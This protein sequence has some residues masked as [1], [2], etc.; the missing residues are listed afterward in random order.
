MPNAVEPPPTIV[1]P[2]V[3]SP[4]TGDAILIED[5]VADALQRAG[6]GFGVGVIQIVGGPGAGK[7]VA[8]EYLKSVLPAR[9]SLEFI[10]AELCSADL[11]NRLV[12]ALRTLAAT[13]SPE[14]LAFPLASPAILICAGTQPLDD[15]PGCRIERLRL[16]AWGDDERIE[17]LLAAHPDRCASVI[18]RLREAEDR[19]IL[20]GT[21]ELCRPVLDQMAADESITSSLEALRRELRGRL[22]HGRARWQLARLALA[23]LVEPMPAAKE[24]AAWRAE[25]EQTGCDPGVLRLARHEAVRVLLAAELVLARIKAGR[26][27]A[28]AERFR[29][30]LVREIARRAD[31]EAL[32]R[33]EAIVR[34]RDAANQPM[35]VSI[36]CARNPAWRWSRREPPN[37]RGAYLNEV[38]WSR[39]RLT[40]AELTGAFLA[41]ADLTEAVLDRAYANS[42]NFS[43][44]C[45]YGAWLRN[46]VALPA[47][48]RGADLRLCRAD[49]AVFGGSDFENAVLDGAS[50][51][52]SSFHAANLASASLRNADLTS[53]DLSEATIT[54]ADFSETNLWSARLPNLP[55]RE[56]VFTRARFHQAD[57]SRCDLEQMVL[58]EA[59]FQ[60]ATLTGALLT[61][62]IMP[63]ANFRGA[64]LREAGLGEVEWEGADLREADLRGATFHMG[65]S[66]SGLLF[67]PWV[68]EGT[69]TGFYTD[70]FEQV[71]FRPPEEIR[72]ANLCG[73]DLR[74]ARI[75][76]VDFYLVD[77]RGAKYTPGQRAHFVACGAILD[78]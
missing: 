48:F 24:L 74:E 58:P 56:A 52:R 45:L 6:S 38:Q 62:T 25:L 26:S 40:R 73:A 22:Q 51:R 9:V 59:D 34:A 15:T 13:K 39:L 2:H 28:L 12:A 31:D 47:Q 10:D 30:H 16:A 14:A 55:L 67:S 5:A 69:R 42:A 68:S 19:H 76:D 1:R 3:I 23:C 41:G 54:G 20:A 66:R 43:G 57:L 53:A 17:Y 61:G 7:S 4:E 21:P 36:L 11:L 33:L 32:R 63:R 44:A 70:E 72:K 46:C 75:E 65:S 50:L 77:L 18:S 71:H 8:L 60:E 37:L 29:A 78:G 27:R 49:D 35:A 64:I